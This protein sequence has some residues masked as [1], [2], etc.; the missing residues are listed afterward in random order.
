MTLLRKS[1]LA[2]VI[3]VA[4]AL[5][6]TASGSAQAERYLYGAI[7]M[8]VNRVGTSFDFPDQSS[9]DE[10][11]LEACGKEAGCWIAV[12]IQNECGSVAQLEVKA[13][14]WTVLPEVPGLSVQPLH[15]YGTGATARE[16]EAAA[17]RLADAP[18]MQSWTFQIVR[19]P[20]ILDTICTSNARR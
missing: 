11:A 12:R 8:G 17:M 18:R 10:A 7:A 15:Y 16:A 6:A 4:G 14:P 19:A 13:F 1:A 5:V 9:A 3:P 20:F 2:L